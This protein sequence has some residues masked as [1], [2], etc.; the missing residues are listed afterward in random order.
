MFAAM[1]YEKA[2]VRHIA[3]HAEVDPALVLYFFRSKQNLFHESV[4][5]S[6]QALI[7]PPAVFAAGP[8]LVAAPLLEHVLSQWETPRG[9]ETLLA[10]MRSAL[11][12]EDAADELCRFF[13]TTLLTQLRESIDMPDADLRCTLV[14]SHLVG[15]T[16]MRYVL[17]MGPLAALAA[18]EVVR[19]V[20]PV[21]QH[22]ISADLFP[23]R[24]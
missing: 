13:E 5:Q 18:T 11:T 14:S 8:E 6:L 3:R 19:L 17:R 24:T 7:P 2:S 4:L 20:A 12:H 22:Y 1:G 10:V 15:L 21:L 23:R 16:M 9:R